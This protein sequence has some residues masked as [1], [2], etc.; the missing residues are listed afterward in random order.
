MIFRVG[1]GEGVFRLQLWKTI[2]KFE[3]NA[4]EFVAMQGFF[5]DV[6]LKKFCHIWNQHPLIC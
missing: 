3:I 5:W 2:V 1:R 6:I 4:F